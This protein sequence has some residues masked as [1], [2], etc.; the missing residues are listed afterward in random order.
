MLHIDSTGDV[1]NLTTLPF[2][3][4]SLPLA[5][6]ASEGLIT[7]GGTNGI[8]MSGERSELVQLPRAP[9]LGSGANEQPE[10]IAFADV[11]MVKNG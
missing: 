11:L 4:G 10:A 6:S 7:I 8:S 1:L 5:L 2:P 3:A 9:P